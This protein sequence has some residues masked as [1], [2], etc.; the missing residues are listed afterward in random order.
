MDRKEIEEF[1]MMKQS[2]VDIKKI[3]D[4]IDSKLD[5]V[6]ECKLDKQVFDDYKNASRSWVQWVPAI[7]TV[8]MAIF[9]MVK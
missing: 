6:I 8:V 4:K 1:G 9:V 2:I 5:N 7:V 3:V